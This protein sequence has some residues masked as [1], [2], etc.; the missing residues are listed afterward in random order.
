MPWDQTPK[1]VT[2]QHQRG[3]DV[4]K[5][6][7]AEA[8][9]RRVPEGKFLELLFEFSHRNRNWTKKFTALNIT[10]EIR[11]RQRR[12][13]RGD[14]GL[15]GFACKKNMQLKRIERFDPMQPRHGQRGRFTLF[16]LEQKTVCS[17]TVR[18]IQ[19]STREKVGVRVRTH[20]PAMSLSAKRT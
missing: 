19:V 14:E 13:L 3:S 20:S 12:L 15:A 9:T 6:I 16:G 4:Q 7:G 18:Q 8:V 1:A 5:V 2:L 10:A 17:L 11:V